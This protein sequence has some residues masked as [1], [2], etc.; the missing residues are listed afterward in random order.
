VRDDGHGHDD[1]RCADADPPWNAAPLFR[2][3]FVDAIAAGACAPAARS[4]LRQS[5]NGIRQACSGY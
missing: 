2:H 1:D 5:G 3:S 4:K